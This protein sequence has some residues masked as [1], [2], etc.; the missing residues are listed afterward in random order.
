GSVARNSAQFR[1][2]EAEGKL[3][4]IPTGD[5][6]SLV[7]FDD[8]EAPI[9]CAMEIA[10][11][12][13][14]RPEIQLRMGIHSGPVNQVIDVSDRSNVAGAG[15][16]TAQR[17]MDCGD[18]GHILLSK[19]VADD[20]SPFPRWRPH[21]HELGEC[22]V[23]HGR[24]IGLVNFYTNE[25]GN[26]EPPRKC[27][28]PP[29]TA[30][31]RPA[32]SSV[33]QRNYALIAAAALCLIVLALG[34]LF[35]FRANIFPA[36]LSAAASSQTRHSIAV[37]PFENATNDPSA[38]YLSEGISEALINSLT[39]LQQ[40]RVI[41]RSTAFHY[42]G[43]DIDPQRVGRELQVAAVLT[44]R[45]RQIQDALS[46]QVD[47]VDTATGAQLWGTAYERKISDIVA[48]KQ[49]I[50]REVTQK[51]KIRLSGEEERRLVKRD[52][53]NAEAYQYYLRGRYFWNQRTPEG[54]KKAIAEFQQ[55]IEHDPN[56][57]LGYT[58]LADSYLL[59]EQY[60]GVPWSEVMPKARAAV[61][62]ALR[63][64][65]S[66]AEPHASSG[67]IYQFN[68]QWTPAE[69]EYRRA[70]SLN[71]N[72]PT[73]HHW[74]GLYLNVRQRF[75]D[76]LEETRRAQE[77]DPLSPIIGANVAITLLLKN[78][79]ALAIEQC[80][81]IIEFNPNHISGYDWLSLAYLH[82]GRLPEAIAVREKVVEM[83]QRSGPQL[84]ILGYLYA[85][86]G[87]RDEALE[88]LRE[89]EQKYA[90]RE[91]TGQTLAGICDALGDPD[92]AFAWLERDFQRH[93]AD[94]Q[95]IVTRPQFAHLCREPRVIGLL[96]RMGLNP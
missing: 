31:A 19:R 38:D 4:R 41:A 72:Y 84:G 17:V 28:P 48:V 53:S 94:L 58:G 43:K 81:R 83:S 18:A 50:A 29:G 21:L 49:A 77:L 69:E 93:S 63:I 57:A 70:I 36:R 79:P 89:L 14:S 45:V 91:T 7:F 22:E 59:L 68:W 5:G 26:P 73:A 54:I 95:F 6:M 24:K 42:K 39:E 88:I 1:R 92:Q 64:D 15:M 8:P 9:E 32:S 40:L 74:Y 71:P 13:K 35:Y 2:A 47:L 80:Q 61:D 23:K 55:A 27:Q 96:Q 34:A 65:D 62:R 66:L 20:L 60:A 33:R 67:L 78:Q 12:L 87:R 51:L 90:R 85:M 30:T 76:A 82:E 46:V 11:A 75:D 3:M 52:T 56:F 25:I 37:L 44:G 86:A 16:D 10:A